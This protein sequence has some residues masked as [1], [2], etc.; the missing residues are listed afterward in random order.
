MTQYKDGQ[1][2]GHVGTAHI[3]LEGPALCYSSSFGKEYF[4]GQM[5]D[6]DY[7]TYYIGYSC[8][9]I[10]DFGSKKELAVIAVKDPN[11]TQ[12]QLDKVYQIAKEKITGAMG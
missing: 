8:M 6:T 9:D 1:F 2:S 7:E 11:M 4:E 3:E 5:V 10:G 12:E